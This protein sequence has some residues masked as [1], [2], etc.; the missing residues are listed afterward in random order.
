MQNL[1]VAQKTAQ[2]ARANQASVLPGAPQVIFTHW[3]EA[4][5]SSGLARHL[6]AAYEH[7]IGRF[8]EFCTLSGQ[9]VTRPSAS[10]FLSDAHRRRLAPPDGR[11]EQGLDW[12]FC[13]WPAL[14]LH[15]GRFRAERRAWRFSGCLA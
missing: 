8:L 2:T 5:H 9:S 14:S 13:Q 11:W 6:Q 3:R 15:K 10:N 1:S 12:F 7:G 4:L